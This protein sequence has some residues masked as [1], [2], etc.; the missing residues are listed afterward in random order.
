MLKA[1]GA[2]PMP[3]KLLE[4][5]GG[6]GLDDQADYKMIRIILLQTLVPNGQPVLTV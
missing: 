2:D 1:K 6:V 3:V 4:E 5:L